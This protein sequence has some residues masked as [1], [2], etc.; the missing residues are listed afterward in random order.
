MLVSSFVALPSLS[1]ASARSWAASGATELWPASLL[2]ISL[3][4]GNPQDFSLSA[5][6][7]SEV[8]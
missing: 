2:Y 6:M 8:N 4:F 7:C 3:P 1:T 5:E